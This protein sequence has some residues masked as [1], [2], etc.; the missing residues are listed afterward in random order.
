M[1][2]AHININGELMIIAENDLEKYALKSWW[3]D[4][5]DNK[6]VLSVGIMH[7]T[8]PSTTVYK[9]IRNKP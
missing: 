3:R 4:W 1:M 2:K 7:E 9:Q 6:V 5:Q 8:D